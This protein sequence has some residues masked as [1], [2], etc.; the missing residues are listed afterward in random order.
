MANAISA[1]AAGDSWS[2]RADSLSRA[3]GWDLRAGSRRVDCSS[4]ALIRWQLSKRKSRK[5]SVII[6]AIHSSSTSCVNIFF[7]LLSF[8]AVSSPKNAV[9]S[10]VT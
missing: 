10:R 4:A 2:D 1:A 3:F 5:Q 7:A 8:T 6:G 9:F